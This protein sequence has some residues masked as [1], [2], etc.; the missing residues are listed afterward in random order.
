MSN[1]R[2]LL[3]IVVLGTVVMGATWWS[4][5]GRSQV[6]D[7]YLYFSC[8]NIS[9]ERLRVIF[10]DLISKNNFYD[11]E[12]EL[13]AACETDNGRHSIGGV[14]II[15]FDVRISLYSQD[16][17]LLA[18]KTGSRFD[19]F[20]SDPENFYLSLELSGKPPSIAFGKI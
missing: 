20:I 19:D 18:K 8:Q 1:D 11:E 13:E 9:N 6:V 16:G 4:L 5:S 12:F 3:I 7:V 10:I 17:E 15:D 14:Q 2:K